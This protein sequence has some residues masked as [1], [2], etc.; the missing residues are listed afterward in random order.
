MSVI[1]AK[2]LDK[3]PYVRTGLF[4]DRLLGGGLPEKNISKFVG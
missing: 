3:V 2:D 1:K 4:V